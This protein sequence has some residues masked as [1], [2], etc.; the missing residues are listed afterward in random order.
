M[1]YILP[2]IILYNYLK[3]TCKDDFNFY[4]LCLDNLVYDFFKSKNSQYSNLFLIKLDELENND[5]CLKNIKNSRKKIEYYFTLS[6][7]LPLY[8]LKRYKNKKMI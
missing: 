2:K 3:K 1:I 7:C 8:I 6:P 5:T 4:V